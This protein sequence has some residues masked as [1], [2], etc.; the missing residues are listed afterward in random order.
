MWTDKSIILFNWMFTRYAFAK[1]GPSLPI[2]HALRFCRVARK[3]SGKKKKKERKRKKG[4]TNPH[5]AH[6]HTLHISILCT[7]KQSAI[8]FNLCLTSLNKS[9]RKKKCWLARPVWEVK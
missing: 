9:R 8:K 7:G 3:V 6:L 2:A 1:G 5:S 4:I